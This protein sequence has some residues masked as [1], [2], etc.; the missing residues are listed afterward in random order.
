[1]AYHGY[2]LRGRLVFRQFGANGVFVSGEWAG[3]KA[4]WN[5]MPEW[6]S[7]WFQGVLPGVDEEILVWQQENAYSTAENTMRLH[8]MFQRKAGGANL[9]GICD[10]WRGHWTKDVKESARTIG[11][12]QVMVPK[13]M[14][15]P[16]Q[17][18]DAELAFAGKATEKFEKARILKEKKEMGESL[19]FKRLD[20]YNMIVAQHARTKVLNEENKV[21]LLGAR[22]CGILARRP[23]VDGSWD[24]LDQTAP[25][26]SK[27]CFEN[28]SGPANDFVNL[29]VF[30][31][32]PWVIASTGCQAS[33]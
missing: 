25:E 33:I 10:A 16:A 23:K 11:M 27:Q 30:V 32:S 4:H 1:M 20:M 17:L 13:G 18:A 8:Q 2:L 24:N 5:L 22:R 29:F 9:L 7:L 31:Q 14:A 19:T 6:R 21:V 28:K 12:P 15:M 3:E 26:W